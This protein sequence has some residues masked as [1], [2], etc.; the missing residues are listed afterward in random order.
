MDDT[1]IKAVIDE[2][3]PMLQ[4]DGGDIEFL[5]VEG[6]A[7]KVRLQGACHGCPHA[8]LTIKQGVEKRIREVVPEVTE[9]IAEQ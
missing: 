5:S 8:A 2:I 3:R 9:V 4:A 1:K 7:V 6:T